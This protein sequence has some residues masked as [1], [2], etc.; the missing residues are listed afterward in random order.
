[1]AYIEHETRVTNPRRRRGKATRTVKGRFT[2]RRGN[3]R[4]RTAS[5]THKRTSNGPKIK[6]YTVKAL[7][8]ELRRRG[9]KANSGS[10]RRRRGSGKRSKRRT[11]RRSNPVLIEL[12]AVNPRR[13]KNV[14]KR[15]TRRRRASVARVHRRRRTNVRRRRVN[16][17]RANP[18]ARRRVHHRRRRRTNAGGYRRVRRYSRR[19][20]NPVFGMSG[21]KNMLTMVA[22]GLVGVAATKFLPT[23][24]PS[25]I[26]ASF[27][28]GP[29]MG[30]IITA[31]GAFAAG[32]IAKR[33][34]PGAF[35]DA[36][37]FGGLMQTAS[38]ALTAFA[39]PSLASRL[40]LSGLGDI[41]PGNFVVP[42]NPVT[43]RAVVAMP[44]G[45]G[46]FRRA[47]G[48]QR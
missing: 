14:A 36:V 25:S 1:M 4:K 44:Q 43:S 31:A 38:V 15:K 20:R 19:R 47:F 42:Q 12:G 21:G 16:R 45:V 28:S 40:A 48:G 29:F 39:P 24:L 17:R 22:G 5:R 46:A 30:V 41:M 33:F 7:R 2:K 10:T 13:R 23:M 11:V 35:A 26:T 32:W 34:M 8:K 6:R 27:G 9:V 3:R 18:V 37:L